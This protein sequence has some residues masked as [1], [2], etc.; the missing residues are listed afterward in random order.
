M[1]RY[2]FHIRNGTR[3]EKD[4]DGTEFD[5]VEQARDDAIKAAREIIAQQ[6]L[7]GEVVKAQLFEIT[8]E[9]GEIVS[10]VPF[11]AV[12]RLE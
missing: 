11:K 9:D 12:M 2:F 3:L 10:T 6:I 7:Q 8:T 1:P 5:T 4:P